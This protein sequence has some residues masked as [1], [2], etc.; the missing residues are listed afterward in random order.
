MK[1]Q[2][3]T[4]LCKPPVKADFYLFM[5]PVYIHKDGASTMTEAMEMS[6]FGDVIVTESLAAK[7]KAFSIAR[8]VQGDHLKI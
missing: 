1:D 2:Y 6:G 5:R 8:K 4:Y 7:V 3:S